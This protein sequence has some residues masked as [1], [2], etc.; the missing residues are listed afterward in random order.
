[1][2][3]YRMV[4]VGSQGHRCVVDA[5]DLTLIKFIQDKVEKDKD[6]KAKTFVYEKINRGYVPMEKEKYL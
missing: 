1:M 2:T 3:N 6:I 5:E 4:V